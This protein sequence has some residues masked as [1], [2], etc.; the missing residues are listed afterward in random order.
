MTT[1]RREC[2][3]ESKNERVVIPAVRW[4]GHRMNMTIHLNGMIFQKPFESVPGSHDS[5]IIPAKLS[6]SAGLVCTPQLYRRL[7]IGDEIICVKMKVIVVS[8]G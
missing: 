7:R 8:G 4:T 3:V 5:Y 6:G 1:T 2:E